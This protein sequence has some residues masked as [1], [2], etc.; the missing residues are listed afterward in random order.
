MKDFFTN[1]LKL[2]DKKN[3]VA[4]CGGM[5]G[6]GDGEGAYLPLD[7]VILK[8][9]NKELSEMDYKRDLELLER[10]YK[11]LERLE[12]LKSRICEN[13]SILERRKYFYESSSSSSM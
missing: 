12:S 8:S 1:F 13:I 10:S 6:I 2:F 11:D 9:P 3:A 7:N 5:G 4:D